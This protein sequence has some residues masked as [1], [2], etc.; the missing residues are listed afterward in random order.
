M[1]KCFDTAFFSNVFESQFSLLCC[2][3]LAI[4]PFM[5]QW[6]L[7][8]D[9]LGQWFQIYWISTAL[10]ILFYFVL[11]PF[12]RRSRSIYNISS[13]IFSCTN[14]VKNSV[15]V[16]KEWLIQCYPVKFPWLRL[17]L[18]WNLIEL[19]PKPHPH[20]PILDERTVLDKTFF[21]L[22]FWNQPTWSIGYNRK[23]T[24]QH[25]TRALC[26]GLTLKHTI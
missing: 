8:K 7:L 15:K 1:L 16:E 14:S 26:H 17:I 11:R 13:S 2:D 20:L 9:I 12:S 18:I 25:V 19:G 24:N 4:F 22:L 5:H 23:L 6:S 21:C 10:C 3:V